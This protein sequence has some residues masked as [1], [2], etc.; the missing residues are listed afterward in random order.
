VLGTKTVTGLGSRRRCRC[1]AV[2]ENWCEHLPFRVT[3]CREGGHSPGGGG[4]GGGCFYLFT[5]TTRGGGLLFHFEQCRSSASAVHP[6]GR[7]RSS[8]SA[9]STSTPG[10]P[11]RLLRTS[12]STG[13]AQRGRH[14]SST[15]P[16]AATRARARV[17]LTDFSSPS[18]LRPYVRVLPPPAP[19]IVSAGRT[20]DLAVAAPFVRCP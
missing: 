5:S 13:G 2:V 19:T 7:A 3:W 11:A 12:P 14:F 15:S 16:A 1:E 20:Y 10:R 18:P 8:S 9:T 6:P 17:R 4:G